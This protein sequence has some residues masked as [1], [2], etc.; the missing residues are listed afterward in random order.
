MAAGW[1][2]AHVGGVAG[3]LGPWARWQLSHATFGPWPVRAGPAWHEAQV[4]VDRRSPP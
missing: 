3:P 4:A 2:D 1:Q